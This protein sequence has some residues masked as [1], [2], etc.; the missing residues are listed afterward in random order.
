[1]KR[2]LRIA[3]TG[4]IGSGKSTV[5]EVFRA[6]G[7]AVI[8]CDSVAKHIMQDDPDVRDAIIELLG[9]D[10]YDDDGTLNRPYIAMQIFHDAVRREALEAI[11]HPMVSQYIEVT[12]LEAE[13]GSIVAAESALVLQ[14]DLW[15]QFDYI[16]LVNASDDS[17][18]ARAITSGRFTDEDV[19]RR[20]RDQDYKESFKGR[21]DFLVENDG[22][23]EQLKSRAQIMVTVLQALASGELPETPLQQVEES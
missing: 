15:A 23:V 4:K 3:I 9:D 14:T 13:P 16:I 1:M 11:V 2:A 19:R 22:T 12:F 7:I 5:S 8:D 20:L 17:V 6:A 18:V 21:A 10:S